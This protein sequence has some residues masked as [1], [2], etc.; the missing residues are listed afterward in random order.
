MWNF[1]YLTE[2]K[3]KGGEEKEIPSARKEEIQRWKLQ[4]TKSREILTYR[5]RRTDLEP[6]SG[7]SW[8]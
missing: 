3:K 8:N 7:K 2:L 5:D 1:E 4:L 6:I